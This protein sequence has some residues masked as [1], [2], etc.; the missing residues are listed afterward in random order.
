MEASKTPP[1]QEFERKFIVLRRQ[2]P[3]RLPKP[4]RIVQAFLHVDGPLVRIRIYDGVRAVLEMK[5]K[6]DFES[7]PLPI[8]LA[9]AEWLIAHEREGAIIEKDRY[10]LPGPAKGLVWEVD[11]FRGANRPLIIA[12]IELPSKKHPLDSAKFPP[13][14]G[15][16]VTDISGFKNKNLALKPFGHWN[17]RL[18]GKIMKWMSF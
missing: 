1:R 7:D 13:Y 3:K 10:R 16:E 18:A 14:I 12:E 8:T 11:V 5:G 6:D 9:Q 15:R 17:K 2:L 4:Q